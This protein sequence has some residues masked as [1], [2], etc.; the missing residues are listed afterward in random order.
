MAKFVYK[1]GEVKVNGVDLS[2]HVRNC[3]LTMA[4][5]EVEDTGLNGPGLHQFIPGLSNE[6][7]VITFASDFA[8]A[9]VDATLYPLYRNDTQFTVSVIAQAGGVSATNPRYE[10]TSCFLFSY[11]PVNAAVG[12]LA[13]TQC[14]FIAQTA[15]TPHTT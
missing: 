7:F 3:Q 11:D 4:K 9:E 5:D 14:T 8:A 6:R 15:I 1:D 2:D 13:E 12:A 10:S